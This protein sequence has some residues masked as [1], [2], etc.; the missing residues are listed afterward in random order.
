MPLI[1]PGR[2]AP[3]FALKDQHGKIHRSSDYEGRHVV[4]YF[5]P[6]DDTP[7]CTTQACEI[8]DRYDE[9]A[10][11][12]AV[13]LGISP[14]S[15]ESHRKFRDKYGLPFRLLADTGHRVADAYGVWNQKSLYGRLLW[16]VERSSFL[17]DEHGRIERSYR[18]VKPKEHADWALAALEA[19]A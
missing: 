17:I 3:A 7:G 14:D 12:D 15:V 9:F 8:R 2:K 10:G 6:K 13:V 4:L 18:K 11:R 5:Y 16:G 1:E 19:D